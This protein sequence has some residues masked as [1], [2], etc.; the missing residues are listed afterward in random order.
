MNCVTRLLLAS[1]VEPR[2]AMKMWSS[3]CFV[4]WPK[5][6]VLTLISV[7]F[8][9]NLSKCKW[10]TATGWQINKR[11]SFWSWGH[12]ELRRQHEQAM[13]TAHDQVR[14]T[15]EGRDC[16]VQLFQVCWTGNGCGWLIGY[17]TERGIAALV[18]N[19]LGLVSKSVS[20]WM[21]QWVSES[22]SQWV[23]ES[24]SQWVSESVSQWVS[25]SVS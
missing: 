14:G 3:V 18:I 5:Y 19:V 11:W 16:L 24:V 21:S 22:V 4:A 15:E 12:L 6:H 1:K 25:E 9:E 2:R 8:A 20:E 13:A 7:L 10:S 17:L 23:S